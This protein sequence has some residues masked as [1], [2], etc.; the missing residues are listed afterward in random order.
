MCERLRA[1]TDLPGLR[2]PAG[3]CGA[4]PRRPV[5]K[6]PVAADAL[7]PHF[8]RPAAGPGAG[9][10]PGALGKPSPVLSTL[11]KSTL[12]SGSVAWMRVLAGVGIAVGGAVWTKFIFDLV[13]AAGHGTLTVSS[14]LQAQ[15]V[16]WE[17]YALTMLLG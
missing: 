13:L 12:F 16:T 10:R 15:L 5:G 7:G 14:S 8:R 4:G 3:Q 17:I 9:P 2:R 11:K 1:A 6:L